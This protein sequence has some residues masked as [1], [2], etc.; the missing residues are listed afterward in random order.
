VA[1]GLV[2]RGFRHR[3]GSEIGGGRKEE[4]A[5]S[6]TGGPLPLG[7]RSRLIWQPRDGPKSSWS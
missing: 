6:V 7:A 5:L 1:V 4:G 3:C 2:E